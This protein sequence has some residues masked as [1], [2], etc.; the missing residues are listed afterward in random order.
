MRERLDA[1]VQKG[2]ST[3]VLAP[4]CDPQDLPAFLD[5]LAPR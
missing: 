2:V 1:F 3:L 5:G 4:L